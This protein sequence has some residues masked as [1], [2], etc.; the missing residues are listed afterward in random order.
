MATRTVHHLPRGCPGWPEDLD[1]IEAP[2]AELWAS[3][4]LDWLARGPRLGIVGTRAPTPYGEGQCERFAARLASAGVTIVSG[5]A[6]GIDQIA[7]RTALEVSGTT[8]AVLGSSIDLIWPTGPVTESMLEQGLVL[9]EL[10]PGTPPRRHHFPHRNRIISGLSAGVLVIEAAYAS[11]S[12]ITAHWAAEQGKSVFVLPGR[13][14]H[15]MARGCHR[16]IREGATL[17]ESPE[18]I[19]AELGLREASGAEAGSENGDPPSTAELH[20][21]LRVLSGETLSVDDL[22]ARLDRA[23]A[24]VLSELVE[25]E[26]D[27]SVRRAP[28]GLYRRG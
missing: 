21:I 4:R 11:G 19:L 10:P 20:P 24:R 13:V 15:P 3:G 18:E 1:P 2:P 12:L 28:G 6:R 16:L 17:V 22:C 7:H 27:G 5:L 23:P 25:L 26:L 14:D 9:S 8:L